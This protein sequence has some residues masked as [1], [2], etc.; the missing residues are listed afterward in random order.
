M[1]FL[2]KPGKRGKD[3]EIGRRVSLTQLEGLGLGEL[4]ADPGLGWQHLTVESLSPPLLHRQGPTLRG[5]SC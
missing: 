5:L 4:V 1:V 2:G 3:G